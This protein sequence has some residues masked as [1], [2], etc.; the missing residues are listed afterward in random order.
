M[1]GYTFATILMVLAIIALLIYAAMLGSLIAVAILAV[2]ATVLLVGLGAGIALAT[3]RMANDKAQV[4]FVNNA[5][6]NLAMMQ[7]MQR[8]QNAQ[9]QTI[10]SQLGQVARLPEPPRDLDSA[11]LIDEGLFSDLDE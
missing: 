1:T 11:L 10:M 7:A 4:D 8:L 6:E 5:K 2:L 9:N 3:Q